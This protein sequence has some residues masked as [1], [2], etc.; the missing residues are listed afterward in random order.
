M[1]FFAI[2]HDV[3]PL[4]KEFTCEF[5]WASSAGVCSTRLP[6]C[7]AHTFSISTQW[8]GASSSVF[9]NRAPS[10]THLPE[11]SFPWHPTQWGP[12]ASPGTAPQQLL[13]PSVHSTCP[14][15]ARS[16]SEGVSSSEALS[17][18]Q[19]V[20]VLY[21]LVLFLLPLRLHF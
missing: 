15:P 5:R 17:Q 2:W 8:P 7:R 21:Y 9:C 18:P 6:R 20:A 13:C 1:F 11:D 16:G 10:V 3:K 12:A 19:V 14:S 4:G